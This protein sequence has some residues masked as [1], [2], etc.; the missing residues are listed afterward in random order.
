MSRGVEKL[1][2][3]MVA[4]NADVRCFAAEALDDSYWVPKE[5]LKAVQK[6]AHR[7]AVHSQLD[8]H[9]TN[10]VTR[11]LQASRRAFHKSLFQP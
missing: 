10:H 3:R 1:I 2:R 7:M 8:T 6:A 4:P 9:F 5:A 11:V